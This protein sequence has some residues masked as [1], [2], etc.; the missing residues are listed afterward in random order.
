VC[1]CVSVCLCVCV[2]VCVRRG[3]YRE[4]RGIGAKAVREGLEREL[5]V[6]APPGS[7]GCLYVY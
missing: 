6:S 7:L 4:E 1:V 2:C 5:P 3:G